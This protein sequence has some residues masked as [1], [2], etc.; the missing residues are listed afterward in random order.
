MEGGQML[1]LGEQAGQLGADGG[2]SASSAAT[3][4][5]WLLSKMGRSPTSEAWAMR[6]RNQSMK[7]KKTRE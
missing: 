5:N 1:A 3:Q 7:R 4:G 2:R 6:L